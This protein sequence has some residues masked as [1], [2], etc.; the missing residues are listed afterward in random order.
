MIHLIADQRHSFMG[1]NNKIC[2]NPTYWC[3]L[4]RIWLS[5]EDVKQKECKCKMDFDM[6]GTHRCGCGNLEKRI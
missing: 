2:K 5:E 1:L 3:R 6:F 4:H